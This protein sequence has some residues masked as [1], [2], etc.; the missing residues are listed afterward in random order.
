MAG[1]S[2]C[3]AR[4]LGRVPRSR[5]LRPP[6]SYIKRG[7]AFPRTRSRQGLRRPTIE[8]QRSN[9]WLNPDATVAAPQ[10]LARFRGL[11]ALQCL[12][13]ESDRIILQ[14][15]HVAL[16]ALGEVDDVQGEGFASGVRFNFGGGNTRHLDRRS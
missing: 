5:A 7:G 3:G 6:A 4:P 1:C 16:T 9:A 14:A 10:G 12:Q 8:R 15:V 11:L 2:I 13:Q